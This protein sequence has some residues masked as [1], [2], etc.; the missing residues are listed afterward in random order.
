VERVEPSRE[1][2]LA[3]LEEAQAAI[4]ASHHHWGAVGSLTGDRRYQRQQREVLHL[5][6]AMKKRVRLLSD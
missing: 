1:K 2:L 5:L 6:D 3:L 4:E